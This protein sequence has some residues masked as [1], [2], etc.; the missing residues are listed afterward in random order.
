M[1]GLGTTQRGCERTERGR[2]DDH[3]MLIGG[4]PGTTEQVGLVEGDVSDVGLS[5][6]GHRDV[7]VLSGRGRSDDDV[8]RVTGDAL[9]A[10]HRGVPE[11]DVLGDVLRR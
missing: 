9:S 8:R 10:V 2:L 6:V 5:A 3:D 11:I 4:Q 1:I 7:E